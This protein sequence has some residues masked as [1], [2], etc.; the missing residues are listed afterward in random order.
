MKHVKMFES[1]PDGSDAPM[2]FYGQD[3]LDLAP[4][5]QTPPRR[6]GS[7]IYFDMLPKGLTNELTR[8]V[9]DM[10]LNADP[11]DWT[12]LESIMP[13]IERFMSKSGLQWKR[14][15]H[16]GRFS[17]TRSVGEFA[18]VL[19]KGYTQALEDAYFS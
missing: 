19:E 9:K 3:D 6:R 16:I 17:A 14:F 18:K 4:E 12:A 8:P 5:V 1:F 11:A 2:F 10:L 7:E 15:P 13:K